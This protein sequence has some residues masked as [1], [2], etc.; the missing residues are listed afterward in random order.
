MMELILEFAQWKPTRQNKK[1]SRES[2]SHTYDHILSIISNYEPEK[3][4]KVADS[5]VLRE[6]ESTQ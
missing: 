1:Q 6:N 2:T 3:K 4:P 5:S